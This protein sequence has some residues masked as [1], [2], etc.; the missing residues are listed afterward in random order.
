MPAGALCSAPLVVMLSDG[1]SATLAMNPAPSI[2]GIVGPPGNPSG[3]STF[4]LFGSDFHAGTTVTIGGAAAAISSMTTT[5][6]L[7]T[8]PP[9]Q[10]GPA[11]L[12]VSSAAGCSDSA[13]YLYQ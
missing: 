10:S 3:G 2:A 4:F 7:A 6:I 9:G 1:Q 11:A 8:A 5:V 13:T 12:V